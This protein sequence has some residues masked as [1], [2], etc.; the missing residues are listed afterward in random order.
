MTSRLGRAAQAELRGAR[1]TAWPRKQ[2]PSLR[3]STRPGLG[4]V[5]ETYSRSPIVNLRDLRWVASSGSSRRSMAVSQEIPHGPAVPAV[6]LGLQLVA[7]LGSTWLG[8]MPRSGRRRRRRVPVAAPPVAV[9]L[10][11]VASSR[12]RQT[13]PSSQHHHM[14]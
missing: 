1:W 9:V 3:R 6:Q 4:R 7:W 10:T 13:R 2:A 14:R 11:L 12:P 8:R 5:L